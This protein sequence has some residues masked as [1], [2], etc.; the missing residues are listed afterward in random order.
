VHEMGIVLNIVRTAEQHAKYNQANKIARMT[1]E[2]GELS[3]VVPAY[4]RDC[5]SAATENTMLDGSELVIHEID[6]ILTCSD[7][8][9]EYLALENLKPDI[10]VCPYCSSEKWTVKMGKDVQIVDIAVYD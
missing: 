2:I 9:R 7:C 3:G 10:P 1:L 6:G 5:W 4:V 8:K